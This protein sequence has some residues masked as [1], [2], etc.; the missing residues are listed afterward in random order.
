MKTPIKLSLY[1][2]VNTPI[3]IKNWKKKFMQDK[4]YG[5]VKSY[6]ASNIR[7]IEQLINKGYLICDCEIKIRGLNPCTK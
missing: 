7:H 3:M 1:L 6:I 5:D 4:Y 2:K